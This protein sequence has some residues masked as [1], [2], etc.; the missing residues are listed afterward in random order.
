MQ[1]VPKN[2]VRMGAFWEEKMTRAR[3]A[4]LPDRLHGGGGGAGAA[5]RRRSR[6]ASAALDTSVRVQLAQ[7]PLHERERPPPSL[8]I[9]LYL[10]QANVQFNA[11]FAVMALYI[12][13]CC[14]HVWCLIWCNIWVVLFH[15]VLR[16]FP[17]P[18]ATNRPCVGTV[19]D[20]Y[21][22][23]ACMWAHCAIGMCLVLHF[24]TVYQQQEPRDF[25]RTRDTLVW[26][27]WADL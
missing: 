26:C 3:R 18:H 25:R 4:F 19:R 20:I 10:R 23:A 16:E 7:E 27:V 15:Y 14:M 21:L 12:C 24:D 17:K 22:S 2:R 1:G 11:S 6:P 9:M 5:C 8:F 13:A